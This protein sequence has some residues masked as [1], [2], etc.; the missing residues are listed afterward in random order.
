MNFEIRGAERIAV[1]GHNGAGKTTLIR[2]IKG[3]IEPATG[4]IYRSA[5]N[6]IYIDQ[7]YLLISNDLTVFQQA[8]QFNDAGLLEHEINIRLNRFLL[9]KEFWNNSCSSLSGGEKMRLI[10][11]CLTMRDQSADII[12]LDEP[13]NNLDLQNLEIL[14]QAINEYKGALIVVSHDEYFLDDIRIQRVIAV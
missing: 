4:K 12:I 7:E 3:D 11:C 14:T 9:G 1:N 10:L 6:I 13:T 2:I 8:E 5:S